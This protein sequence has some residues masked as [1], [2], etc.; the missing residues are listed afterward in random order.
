M[1]FCVKHILQI[2]YVG[3]QTMKATS[4]LAFQ[5][6]GISQMNYDAI[7]APSYTFDI[8]DKINNY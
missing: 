4:L 6:L 8:S 7:F 2:N 1:I 5:Y 3:S